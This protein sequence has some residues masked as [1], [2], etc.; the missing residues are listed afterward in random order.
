MHKML[1]TSHH[2]IDVHSPGSPTHDA[3]V[4]G[5][6]GIALVLAGRPLHLWRGLAVAEALVEVLHGR[7]VKIDLGAP[8]RARVG[9]VVV[10]VAHLVRKDS[11]RMVHEAPHVGDYLQGAYIGGVK[12]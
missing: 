10:K 1:S 8:G 5:A 4:P 6:G 11:L 7:V 12:L 2:L 9:R 3:G